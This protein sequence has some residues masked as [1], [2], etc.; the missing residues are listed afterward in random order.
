[1]DCSMSNDACATR[2]VSDSNDMPKYLYYA[3]LFLVA[4]S[5]CVFVAKILYSIAIGSKLDHV[6]GAWIGLAMDF[7]EGVF[8]RPLFSEDV[9]FGGTRFFPLFFSLHALMIGLFGTPILSGHIVSLFSGVL[10]FIGCFALLRQM[11]VRP[12]LALGM[13]SVLLSGA[14]IQLGLSTIRGDILPLAFNIVGLSCFLL[15]RPTKYRVLIA[16]AFF[17]L[18]FSA[19]VTAINGI[20]S[21]S[22]WLVLRRRTKEAIMVLLC[23]AFGYLVFLSILYF[24]TSGRVISIF[25]MC[26]SGGANLYSV[27]RSPL[28]FTDVVATNDPECLLFLFGATLVI[29]RYR[30]ALLANLLFLFLLVSMGLTLVIFGSPGTEYNH[31]VDV[32]TASVLLVGSMEFSRDSKSIRTSVYVYIFLVAFSTMLNLPPLKGMLTGDNGG[33]VKKY[34][35]EITC[36]FD[37]DSA[38]VLSENPMLPILANKRPYILDPFMIR[39]MIANSTSIRDTV[40]ECIDRKRFSAIVF[41]RDPL[42]EVGWYSRTHFG[43]DFVRRVIH[44][45]EKRI[46]RNPYVIYLP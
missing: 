25:R 3:F 17:V 14:S 23:T 38:K 28:T 24:G 31:L 46:S 5:A 19:K 11:E 35:R 45:Y 9:G 21:L 41:T 42:T 43:Y 39:L 16:S 12:V 29:S 34:P 20:V 33:I 7:S 32:S 36:L 22:L 15:Q 30:K 18:A 2:E 37:Q 13:I 27:L 44:N 6:A 26:S 10:L 1:M 4:G 40:F 8:Y